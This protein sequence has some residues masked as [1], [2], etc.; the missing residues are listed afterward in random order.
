MKYLTKSRYLDGLQCPKLIWSRWNAEDL[1]PPADQAQQAFMEEGQRVGLLARQLFPGGIEITPDG[2]AEAI[3]DTKDALRMRHPLYEAAFAH[4]ECAVRVDV[5]NSATDGCWDIIEVKSTTD[6]EA[7]HLED[8]AFQAY[9]L[10]G[11]GVSLGRFYLAH[12]DRS[13]VKAGP[14]DPHKFFILRDVTE[15]IS[16]LRRTIVDNV[17]KISLAIRS[18]ECPKSRIGSHCEQPHP[19][20]L[21][22]TCWSFLP[23]TSVVEL[24]RGSGRRFD[25]LD[26][27]VLKL[28]DIPEGVKLSVNQRIQ[29][30]AA[31]TGVPHVDRAAIQKFLDSIKYPAAFLDFESWSSAIPVLDGAK[32]YAQIVFQFSLHVLASPETVPEHHGFLAS[33]C[34][35]PRPDFLRSLRDVLPRSG[36]VIGYN[37]P[38]ELARLR[39]CGEAFP[40]FQP[41]LNEIP[42]RALDLL[43]VFRRF[44]FYDWR[45]GGSCS[46]KRVLPA[47]TTEQYDDLEIQNG[48]TA[49]MEFLRITFGGV[50]RDERERVRQALERYC[51]RDTA[52]LISIISALRLLV[53]DERQIPSISE[54]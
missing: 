2:L 45:Q 37:V 31:R 13:F 53:E 38:F 25:L 40:E 1:V 21:K 18:L 24:Y 30:R 11:A 5:L 32:P 23:A 9:V 54:M 6:V 4:D 36:S 17:N 41:W 12:V 3:S 50:D 28:A 48:A 34:V 27:G 46:I 51:E 49:S 39:E 35:D 20:A 22:S 8:I 43:A 7:V 15:E 44:A 42:A 29:R 47:I 10:A 26:Q 33:G 52:S 19:C 14:I 16:A